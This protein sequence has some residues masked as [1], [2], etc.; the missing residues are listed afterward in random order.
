MVWEEIEK[1]VKRDGRESELELEIEQIR[2]LLLD[3]NS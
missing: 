3:D 2:E 1:D